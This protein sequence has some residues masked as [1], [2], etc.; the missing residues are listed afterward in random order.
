MLRI[1]FVLPG[2]PLSNGSGGLLRSYQI[3]RELQEFAVVDVLS[4]DHGL[5]PDN[6]IQEFKKENRYL[7]RIIV[8]AGI[9]Y[10]RQNNQLH[11]AIQKLTELENYDLVIGRY[12]GAAF[13][14]GLF[15]LPNFILD[16][17]DCILEILWQRYCDPQAIKGKDKNATNILK[18][19][20]QIAEKL[21]LENLAKAKICLFAKKS[22]RY[23][24]SENFRV[25]YNRIPFHEPIACDELNPQPLKILFIGSLGYRPNYEGLDYFLKNIW[26]SV[27][28]INSCVTLKIVGGGLPKEFSRR[29]SRIRNLEMCGF[30]ENIIDA[31]SDCSFSIS[32]I[33]LGSGTHMKVLESLMFGLTMVI[34][35]M[36]HRGYEDTLRHGEELFVAKNNEA[37]ANFIIELINS[38]EKRKQM[39]LQGREK[40]L[41]NF[42][43]DES[44]NFFKSL[45][46]SHFQ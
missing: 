5:I 19:N 4:A 7:G 44:S 22:N 23:S 43:M 26:P 17:D 16:C 42:T 18:K 12:Y 34:S 29:W 46:I 14:L 25:Y 39:S 33:Y 37:F 27:L 6:I 36:S 35:P 32:P 40:V 38:P 3:Y 28:A 31:Y 2:L 1:L 10:E 45:A 41:R 24:W 20:Y 30:V 15:A 8:P 11:K 9:P 13:A 21:Y